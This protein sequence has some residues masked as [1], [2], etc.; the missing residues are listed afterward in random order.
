MKLDF[1]IGIG[2][3]ETIHEIPDLAR[4][5]EECGSSDLTLT[6][7]P[8]HGRD[9]HAMMT[10]AA[11]STSRIRIGHGVIDPQLTH[12]SVIATATATINELSGGR[13]F[14]GISAGGHM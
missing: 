5:A 10:V 7:Q 8:I 13:A 6:D 2:R 9:V 14:V 11:M 3:N 4:V 12:P 1:S